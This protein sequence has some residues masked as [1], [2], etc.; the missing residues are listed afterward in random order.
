M[1]VLVCPSKA[2]TDLDPP[3]SFHSRNIIHFL[4]AS[5]LRPSSDTAATFPRPSE[6]A[7]ASDFFGHDESRTVVNHVQGRAGEFM[8]PM[9][10]FP[11]GLAEILPR[12]V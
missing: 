1:E 11:V 2:M 5:S 6:R 9:E 4:F 10:A 3:T 12:T 7:T 8:I